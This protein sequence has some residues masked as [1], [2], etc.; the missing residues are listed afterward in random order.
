MEEGEFYAIET[1]A[2]NGKAYVVEDLECS[3]YMK[4]YDAPHVPL[5]VKSSKALLHAI[6]QN[7]GTLAFCRRWL[8]DLGQ[9]RHL[10]ALKNLVDND[11]VQPY[12]PLCDAKGSWNTQFF[13]GQHARR[14]SPVAM[15]SERHIAHRQFQQRFDQ[16]SRTIRRPLAAALAAGGA[17]GCAPVFSVASR[18]TA[19]LAARVSS[20]RGAP[21]ERSIRPV[22]GGTSALPGAL[23]GGSILVI[24]SR[25][26]L[27]RLR[28]HAEA[29][30]PVEM[31]R[32]LGK[33]ARET[34][35]RT[36]QL[37]QEVVEAPGKA[38]KAATDTVQAASNTAQNLGTQA[39]KLQD[40]LVNLKSVPAELGEKFQRPFKEV[41]SA[42]KGAGAKLASLQEKA[43]KP[44]PK[45]PEGPSVI[46]SVSKIP[47]TIG[48][49]FQQTKEGVEKTVTGIIELPDRLSKG[50][51]RASEAVV[52]TGEAITSF[53]GRVQATADYLVN[54]PANT[55]KKVETFTTGV[56]NLI[57]NVV[58][59]PE[60]T[61]KSVDQTV[62]GVTETAEAIVSFPGRVKKTADN[63]V[64]GVTST[65]DA[66][67]SAPRKVKESVDSVKQ[68]VDNVV[69]FP[70]KVKSSVDGAIETGA[71]T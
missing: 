29:E 54:L 65:V 37:A 62:T 57:T 13:S 27:K 60:R 53:P 71:D 52:S 6:E 3:H 42:A 18:G 34:V 4:I 17:F 51:T 19:E 33:Q 2:S 21:T 49:R 50:A 16:E 8:D 38:A 67:T 69:S 24:S 23:I 44:K 45:E 35:E 63:V 66:V 20:Q 25:R 30:G 28:R 14:S 59:F 7:F 56:N 26:G 1:F 55:V 41:S 47:G 22:F 12:P 64:G 40:N 5:R 11:I 43:S 39:A 31:A 61:A 58:T 32:R 48:Q 9:T 15:T 46:E 68:S 10:M 70:G 36:T